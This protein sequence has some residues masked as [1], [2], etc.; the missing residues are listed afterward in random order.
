M[1][2]VKSPFIQSGLSFQIILREPENQEIFDVDDDEII[3]NHVSDYL[4]K[5]LKVISVKD[6]ESELYGLVVRGTNIIGWTKLNN[7]IKLISKPIE[8]IR[9]DLTHF[10]TPQIN[11]DLGF[12]VD[13]NLLFQEKNYSSRA[14]YLYEGEILEAIFN[15]GTFSGFV[16]TEDIDRAVMINTKVSIKNSTLF[17]QDSAKNKTIDLSLD[18]EQ[19]DFNN[20]NIDMVFLK[21]KSVRVIIKKK[22]Y[23][24]SLSDLIDNEMIDSLESIS[25][26][27]YNELELEQLDIITNFQEERKESKSAIVRLI[28][29]NIN[30]QKNHKKEEKAQYER[31]YHNL[32]NSKLGKIQTKYWSWRNRRKS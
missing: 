2:D 26:E 23:W 28:N 15:K 5:A 1:I 31:L 12:K 9:V 16:K 6:I 7:S 17:Y 29:E 13:Y 27:N 25:Y 18:E 10:N 19:F 4:N 20:V 14:L 30:L 24:I 22:K 3:V 11:R 32:R 8:T 21:A